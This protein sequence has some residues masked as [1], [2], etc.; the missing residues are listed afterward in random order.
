MR[1]EALLHSQVEPDPLNA[2]K[3]FREGTLQDLADS[4]HEY[5]LLENLVVRKGDRDGFF[6][7]VAGERRW[8]ALRILIDDGRRSENDALPV[9]IIDKESD[10]TFENL[11]ENIHRED[12]SPWEL[13]FKFNALA[14]AGYTQQEI[15][16]RLGKTQAFISRM[17]TIARGLHPASIERLNNA[18][19]SLTAGDLTKV[20]ALKDA[21]RKPDEKAQREIIDI[22]L[23]TRQHRKR[24]RAKKT[25]TQ[26]MVRRLTHMRT[27]L[28]VPR[29]AQPYVSAIVAYLM[30]DTRGVDFP[31]E[32]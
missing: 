19:T 18:R 16:T 31:E 6:F 25:D 2:R 9:M 28:R 5:G 10:G 1:F 27:E 21:D 20:S 30:G 4:I 12:V 24:R 23:G 8:R 22:M 29:H 11:V 3:T 13:G 7:L 14:D 32:L 17:G 26:K 15:G